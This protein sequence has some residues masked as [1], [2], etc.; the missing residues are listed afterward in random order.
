[1]PLANKVVLLSNVFLVPKVY[2]IDEAVTCGYWTYSTFKPSIY[3][4][5]YMF[6][7]QSTNRG[8]VWH[9]LTQIKP[10]NGTIGGL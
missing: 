10:S 7:L 9:I 1:M 4:V 6:R 8:H 3:T 5:Y 2:A